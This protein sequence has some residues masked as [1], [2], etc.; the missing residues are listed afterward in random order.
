MEEKFILVDNNIIWRVGTNG[1]LR[2]YHSLSGVLKH[3]FWIGN[4][5]NHRTPEHQM[6]ISVCNSAVESGIMRPL[7]TYTLI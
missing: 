6:F 4:P 1:C 3:V 2:G 5:P 7:S